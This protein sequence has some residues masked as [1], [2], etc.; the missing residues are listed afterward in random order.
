MKGLGM[1]GWQACVMCSR[2]W[3]RSRRPLAPSVWPALPFEDP[4][5]KGAR[6]VHH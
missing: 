3:R 1:F 4:C 6:Y 2:D 5:A